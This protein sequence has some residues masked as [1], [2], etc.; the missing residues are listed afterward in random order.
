MV[1]NT[2]R[3]AG[4]ARRIATLV[5]PVLLA[6]VVAV[7]YAVIDEWG[8]RKNQPQSVGV[9]A[10]ADKD[11]PGLL[12]KLTVAPEASMNGYSREKFPHWDT[13]KPEHEFGA[14][15]A[16]YAK[17]TTREVM[18][19]RDATGS[20]KLDAKTCDLTVSKGGG[21]RDQYGVLDRKSGKLEEYKFTTDPS[22]MDADHIVALA[23]AWRS[24]AASKDEN[25]R[26][27]IANDAGNLVVSDPTANRSKGDQ[28][29]S[30]YLPPGAFRCVYIDHYIKVKIK[31]ALTIDSDEQSALRTAVDDCVKRG[32]FK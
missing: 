8:D 15:F 6:V 9:T 16:Q 3:R 14:D 31:Y 29:P 23:E 18:L 24:G 20:V 12:P 13:N 7:G 30:D 10:V 4:P 5:A 22:G 11:V 25:T 19:L 26:R 32:A 21:W 17:C 27:N 28:D 2:S 1:K